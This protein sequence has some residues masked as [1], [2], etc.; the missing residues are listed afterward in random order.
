MIL[1]RMLVWKC[2]KLPFI[3]AT[4]WIYRS[5]FV[6]TGIRSSFVLRRN[7]SQKTKISKGSRNLFLTQSLSKTIKLKKEQK[8]EFVMKKR[9]FNWDNGLY[10]ISDINDATYKNRKIFFERLANYNK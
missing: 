6:T 1:R 7:I 10:R 3:G 2:R 9:E 5:P 8:K 4:S